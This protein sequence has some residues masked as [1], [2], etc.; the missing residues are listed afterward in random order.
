MYKACIHHACVYMCSL[1]SEVCCDK[2]GVTSTC[3]CNV[4][5]ENS[6]VLCLQNVHSMFTAS[7]LVTD[8]QFQH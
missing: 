2:T 6:P 3:L 4:V 1:C 5:T 7:Y 8:Q